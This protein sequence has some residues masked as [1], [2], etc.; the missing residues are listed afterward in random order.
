MFTQWTKG[1][2][3]KSHKCTNTTDKILG[4]YPDVFYD[5]EM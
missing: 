5:L 3:L 2:Q 4:K 1:V